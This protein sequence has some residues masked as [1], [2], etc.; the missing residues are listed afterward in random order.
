MSEL[1]EIL[2]GGR[3]SPRPPL[4]SYEWR[5]EPEPEGGG[6]GSAQAPPALA[7]GGA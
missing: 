6:S 1:S 4:A 5:A 2:R 3:R 7:S